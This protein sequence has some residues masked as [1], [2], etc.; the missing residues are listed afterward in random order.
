MR[1]L[2]IRQGAGAW[3]VRG[4]LAT[5]HTGHV[6]DGQ[7]RR[8]CED[9]GCKCGDTVREEA[10]RLCEPAGVRAP[11]LFQAEFERTRLLT[12]AATAHGKAAGNA[13]SGEGALD[14]EWRTHHQLICGKRRKVDESQASEP[15]VSFGSRI[16][17]EADEL[18]RR[19]E[20]K[21]NLSVSKLIERALYALD[22][23]LNSVEP[24]E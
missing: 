22:R 8:T 23:E 2:S 7:I 16:S 18:R 17:L 6:A 24:A 19:L 20:Q 3:S 14:S 21:I 13:A 11:R 5:K 1:Q 12:A 15:S 10:G 9:L 4:V